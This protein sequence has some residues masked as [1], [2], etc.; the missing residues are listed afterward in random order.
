MSSINVLSLPVFNR[1]ASGYD[2]L[3]RGLFGSF[4]DGFC[5]A[6]G[7]AVTGMINDDGV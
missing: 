1:D 3:R 6:V 2:A 7:M 5:H 4:G